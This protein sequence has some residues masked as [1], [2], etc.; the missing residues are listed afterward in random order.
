QGAGRA[1]LL[2]ASR[3]EAVGVP[4]Q[5]GEDT[6]GAVASPGG[7]ESAG[8]TAPVGTTVGVPGQVSDEARGGTGGAG[9]PAGVLPGQAG[10]AV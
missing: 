5:A 10:G 2:L 4:G 9:M 6:R 3:A 8:P 7:D 1:S